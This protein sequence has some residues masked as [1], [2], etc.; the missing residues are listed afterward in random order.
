MTRYDALEEALE[1]LFQEY[2]TANSYLGFTY[3]PEYGLVP[4]GKYPAQFKS[5]EDF[6]E[7]A[8]VIGP[9]AD[10]EDLLIAI[11]ENPPL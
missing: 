5:E 11:E 2:M 7:K 6:N 8:V 3:H 4:W 10:I 9:D 1:L